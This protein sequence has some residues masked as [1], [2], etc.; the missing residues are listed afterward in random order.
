[1]DNL[2][3]KCSIFN[4]SDPTK[5]RILGGGRNFTDS[6]WAD[7]SFALPKEIITPIQNYFTEQWE[8]ALPITEENLTNYVVTSFE[9]QFEVKL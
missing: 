8:K 4:Y 6:D 2:H 1:M 5:N 3:V 7:I 9:K